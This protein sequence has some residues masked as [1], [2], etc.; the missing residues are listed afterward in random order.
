[1]GRDKDKSVRKSKPSANSQAAAA[2]VAAM[3][4]SS[5]ITF[6]AFDPN[7][8]IQESEVESDIGEQNFLHLVHLIM[9]LIRSFQPLL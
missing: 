5:G 6:S 4:G 8:G 7:A 1:M 9:P 2:M 3:G